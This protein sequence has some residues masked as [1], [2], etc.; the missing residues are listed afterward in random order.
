MDRTLVEELSASLVREY[1]ARKKLYRS[2]KLLDQEQI[3]QSSCIRSRLT[4]LKALHIGKLVKRNKQHGHHLD[5]MVEVIVHFLLEH[6]R[7]SKKP[8]FQDESDASSR[9]SHQLVGAGDLNPAFMELKLE[10]P[11]LS[12]NISECSEDNGTPAG[13]SGL[14]L[15]SSTSTSNCTVR[16]I[17]KN[18]DMSSIQGTSIDCQREKLGE[19]SNSYAQEDNRGMA[20]SLTEKKSQGSGGDNYQQV[21]E[22]SRSTSYSSHTSSCSSSDSEGSTASSSEYSTESE[23]GSEASM[24]SIIDLTKEN[25]V[26]SGLRSGDLKS[27]DF[28]LSFKVPSVDT[29]LVSRD[30]IDDLDD[31][32]EFIDAGTCGL[33]GDLLL[34]P[35]KTLECLEDFDDESSLQDMLTYEEPVSGRPSRLGVDTLSRPSTQE[36]GR[37]SAVLSPR[38]VLWLSKNGELLGDGGG[39]GGDKGVVKS[40]PVMKISP[41]VPSFN[42]GSIFDSLDSFRPHVNGSDMKNG[43]QTPLRAHANGHIPNGM[44]GGLLNGHTQTNGSIHN[45]SVPFGMQGKKASSVFDMD[46]DIDIATMA[47]QR[48]QLRGARSVRGMMAPV[49]SKEEDS[50]SRSATRRLQMSRLRSESIHGNHEIPEEDETGIFPP[51]SRGGLEDRDVLGSLTTRRNILDGLQGVNYRAPGDYFTDS[52]RQ[53]DIMAQSMRRQS[54]RGSKL[55]LRDGL[56]GNFDSASSSRMSAANS[57]PDEYIVFKDESEEGSLERKTRIPQK[58][59]PNSHEDIQILNLQGFM[60]PNAYMNNAGGT[61]KRKNKKRKGKKS[62]EDGKLDNAK[63][64][65]KSSQKPRRKRSHRTSKNQLSDDEGEMVLKDID[66][67]DNKVAG[68]VLGPK[69]INESPGRP[70]TFEEASDL[71]TLLMGSPAQSLPNEWKIQNFK[72]NP[73]SNLSYGLI[74][75]KGGPCGVLACVQAYMMKNL[76]FGS[77]ISPNTSPISP[78]RPS[79][80]EWSWALATSITEILWKAGQDQ[81]AILALPGS[82][83]HFT[84]EGVG[85][86]SRDGLTETLTIHEYVEQHQLYDAVT[87]HLPAFTNESSAG[88]VVLLL[89]ALLSRGVENVKTDMD[90]GGG[91]LVNVHGYSSQEIVNLLITGHATTNTFNGE[92]ILGS[93]PEERVVL[94]GI[95]HRS[96]I[97]FLSLFEHYDC[98]KVG[99]YLKSPLYPVWVICCESHFSVIFSRDTLVTSDMPSIASFDLYYYDGLALQEDEIRLT[100]DLEKV[101]ADTNV[102]PPLE[103]CIRT[104]WHGATIEWNGMDPIL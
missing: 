34:T 82:F 90:A 56:Y 12:L 101:E 20:L 36:S 39:V 72:Q 31:D 84:E 1:L 104:K 99:S 30:D 17:D 29:M 13:K 98:Y 43:L 79:Q 74:Q 64:V 9:D 55:S 91:H 40:P 94:H 28:Q 97:G 65:N 14:D 92:Q 10:S 67:L 87:N 88:C 42:G 21:S 2:L 4:L 53:G 66:E 23:S 76:I 33:E 51:P 58:F 38:H 100:L 52:E 62:S 46:A 95:Q 61:N 19:G 18:I 27:G 81:K 24:S 45:G 78:L 77:A 8:E 37:G 15:S 49:M 32:V 47:A 41:Q 25:R 11:A 5:S 50:N 80:R 89:S 103:L 3:E 6:A 35:K 86:Y 70:I 85:R 73:N 16:E 63:E 93:D 59:I 26:E 83:P 102:V 96:E 69:H 57:S 60:D 22:G 48:D 54:L 71:K 7:A 68:L 44:S 75:K